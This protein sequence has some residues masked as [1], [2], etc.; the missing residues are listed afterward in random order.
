MPANWERNVYGQVLSSMLYLLYISLMEGKIMVSQKRVK[1]FSFGR[2]ILFFI[3]VIFLLTALSSLTFYS[4]LS[5][6]YVIPSQHCDGGDCCVSS[7]CSCPNCEHIIEPTDICPFCGE[8]ICTCC[9]VCGFDRDP[10]C[11][12]CGDYVPPLDEFS[13]VVYD[14]PVPLLSVEVNNFLLFAP[15]GVSSWAIVNVALTAVGIVSSLIV[16][17]LSAMQKQG[18]NKEADKQAAL[19]NKSGSVSS[20]QLLGI[21][22]LNERYNKKRRLGALI[23][24]YVFSL[25]AAL[26][27]LL[28]QNFSGIVALFD[29]WSLLHAVLFTGILISGRLVFRTNKI[30]DERYGLENG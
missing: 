15:L 25:G 12:E 1:K 2:R 23:T 13:H 20:E 17:I 18:E 4:A 26:L 3:S 9:A 28:T 14:E 22:E 16:I 5:E 29:F 30:T 10:E 19:L 6:T 27:L 7:L 8:E 21:I 11:P 24:T